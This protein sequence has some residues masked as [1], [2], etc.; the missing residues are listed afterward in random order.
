V[1]R[2]IHEAPSVP[3]Y[4]DGRF[5]QRLTEGLVITIEPIIAAGS[6]QGVLA[7]DHWTIHTA[8]G[9]LSAHYE[10]SVVITKGSPILLTAA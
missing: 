4:H 2:T 5:R 7:G 3:N 6:G 8:D 10:H 1:G 9:S